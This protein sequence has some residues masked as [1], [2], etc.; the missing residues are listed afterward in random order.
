MN[1]QNVWKIMKNN[2][3]VIG[4]QKRFLLRKEAIEYLGVSPSMMNCLCFSRKVKYYRPNGKDTYFAIEDL[5][6]YIMSGEVIE[7]CENKVHGDRFNQG[8]KK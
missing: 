8:K 6:A 7:V 3:S 2:S 1:L 5:D 4:V